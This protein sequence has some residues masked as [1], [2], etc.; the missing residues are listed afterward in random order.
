[1]I[2]GLRHWRGAVMLLATIAG[3]IPAPALA[4]MVDG[5][6]PKTAVAAKV[7]AKLAAP[8]AWSPDAESQFMLDVRIRQ[9]QLGDGVRAYQTPEGACL[10]LS[11][12]ITALDLPMTIDGAQGTASGWAFVEK[13]RL[14]LEFTRGQATY[15][16]AGTNEPIPVGAARQTPEG[17]CV[18]TAALTR[19]FGISFRPM[20]N[21][22]ILILQSE[23]KL[24]AELTA[25]RHARAAR[26]HPAK[27]DLASLPQVRLPYRL[28][29]APALDF[30]V[31]GGVTYDA[32]TGT[33]INRR[34]AIVAAGEIA[35][36]SY[37][38]RITTN[39]KGLPSNVRFRAY[40]ADPEGG[41]LGPAK[42][43][44]F[45]FGD[46]DSLPT[47]TTRSI[48]SGRGAMITNRPL[49]QPNAFDRT[50][51][52][53]ELPPGWEAEVYRN[54]ELLGFA[55]PSD[56]GRYHFD[57]VPLLFGENRIEIVSYGP[58]GQT[59]SRIET[60]NV[61]GDSVTPG[62]T[63]YW[64]GVVDPGR[65]LLD[66]RK[67]R[68]TAVAG[69]PVGL[70]PVV[71]APVKPSGREA[72]LKATALIE[73]GLSKRMSVAALVQSL[74]VDDQR[75]TFVEGS[76]RRAIGP[77]LVEVAAARDSKG[78]TAVRAAMLAKFGSVN[79][80][81]QSLMLHDFAA[82]ARGLA[83]DHRIAIDAPLKI[84]RM[85]LP[86]HGDIRLAQSADGR[87]EMQAHVRTS[88]LLS[89]FN[90][91]TDIAYH[92]IRPGGGSG[93]SPGESGIDVGL[94][95][96]GRIGRVR[97]RGSS[98]WS[99]SPSA[100]FRTA[101]LS[102]YWSTSENADWE[103]VVGYDADVRRA[104]LRVSHIRR[105]ST[106][107]VAASLEG[108][109]DGSVAVGLGL[110]FSLDAGHGGLRLSRQ[111]LAS[112]GSVR[113]HVYRDLNANGVRDSDEPDEPGALITAGQRIADA[114][115]DRRG[116]AAVGGLENYRAVAIGLDLESLKDPTLVP[117]KAA[118]VVVP[119][120]G[121]SAEVEIGLS[122]GG[123]VE[124]VLV[125]SGGGGWEGLSI[126]LVDVAGQVIA[127]QRSDYDGYFLFDRVGYGTYHVRLTA[128]SAAIAKCDAA[129][130]AAFTVSA[131]T[132]IL[133]LGTLV[134][135]RG[136]PQV[137]AKGVVASDDLP[138]GTQ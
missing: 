2:R 132:A 49:V 78:G 44:Q 41:L 93:G 87:S 59:R 9:T 128:A 130:G 94:I 62:K 64:V 15:G 113:A 97:V 28:W 22:S 72:G 88:V 31:D 112:S 32:R 73:H 20:L 104:R 19:W 110:N 122:G 120:P 26:V 121:V 135:G 51:L 46:V 42:A 80:S 11:D 24:P 6:A 95:G 39:A 67:H 38:A 109:S 4:A 29:R 25:E 56:D 86:L 91:A 126:E 37:D 52:T 138:T 116:R 43:T 117:I 125:K 17:W 45:A 53:G 8:G 54:G 127:T 12:L 63:Q 136:P 33:R 98:Q 99:V 108:A 90:L 76:I 124:G 65:D 131:K 50:T 13:N 102:A 48:S 123:D 84:G 1:M 100:K 82:N 40:R 16:A 27:I 35:Q 105:F 129:I 111:T 74:V 34:A 58:Q 30:V 118:Q 14:K 23:A 115:T 114:P 137:A 106:M 69:A 70:G 60:L 133:R 89:R 3:G 77:A 68:I 103:G 79:V 47:A 83:G 134:L 18:D 71:A 5:V 36:M 101:E 66:F 10:V 7:A 81:A 21:A 85:S 107:A 119:R 61:A 96:S 57:D 75:V 55:P 92:R